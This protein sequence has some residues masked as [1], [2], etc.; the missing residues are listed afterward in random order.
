[1]ERYYGLKL[2]GLMDD[3][4]GKISFDVLITDSL[5][6]EMEKLRKEAGNTDFVTQDNE[7]YYNFYLE[8]D[9]CKKI[10]QL[11]G[12]C[13]HGEKDD[14]QEYILP[15]TDKEQKDLLFL[16]IKELKEIIFED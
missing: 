7:V 8:I 3:G 11:T 15:L 12:V 14:Y 9:I 1:M 16:A 6:E 10:I 4:N 5:I 13:N 2:Y